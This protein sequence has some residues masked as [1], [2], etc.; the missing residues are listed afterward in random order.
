MRFV[1]LRVDARYI[2]W[3]ETK[4]R[5]NLRKQGVDFA[6]LGGFFDGQLVTREDLRFAYAERRFRSIGLLK[7]WRI[8]SCGR[9][10]TRPT[11]SSF[12]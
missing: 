6:L 4:R 7:A 10:P 9:L 11:I 5:R 8:S 1:R 12:S 3:D 2:Q